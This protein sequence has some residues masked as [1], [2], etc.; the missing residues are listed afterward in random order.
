M[1][2]TEPMTMMPN[3]GDPDLCPSSPL[4]TASNSST[5]DADS[6]FD[7]LLSNSDDDDDEWDD[8]SSIRSLPT[9]VH[10]PPLPL[11]FKPITSPTKTWAIVAKPESQH[12]EAKDVT[13]VDE[14]DGDDL[15]TLDTDSSC[16]A[17][18]DGASTSAPTE[19]L[20][21]E[22]VEIASRPAGMPHRHRPPVSPLYRASFVLV[23]LL[24]CL[25]QVWRNGGG[26]VPAVPKPVVQRL[27]HRLCVST[28]TNSVGGCHH[29]PA[30]V[31]IVNATT[32][33]PCP[34]P[35]RGTDHSP[36][37]TPSHTRRLHLASCRFH[38]IVSR[39][40]S[41]TGRMDSVSLASSIGSTCRSS[42]SRCLASSSSTRSSFGRPSQDP[43]SWSRRRSIGQALALPKAGQGPRTIRQTGAE[44][45]GSA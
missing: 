5:T 31:V 13:W 10:G 18:S 9:S 2:L 23:A 24:A 43:C 37:S 35:H 42:R 14:D 45:E 8:M 19:P 40:L 17:P 27:P 1:T 39:S 33:A 3:E 36:S 41:S 15:I 22:A 38:S 32:A 26:F 21:D 28:L 7:L 11:P 30:A 4:F 16:D 29:R 12:A 20:L 34:A 44:I 6:D 25:V